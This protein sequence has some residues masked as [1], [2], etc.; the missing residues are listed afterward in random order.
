RL[1]P[2]A[3]QA[4]LRCALSDPLAEAAHDLEQ[5]ACAWL[6]R[7]RS[8]WRAKALAPVREAGLIEAL[9]ALSLAPP[10]IA[11]RVVR[12]LWLAAVRGPSAEVEAPEGQAKT[13]SVA[14]LELRRA[15]R[16]IARCLP[17]ADAHSE[18][19][20]SEELLADL[21]ARFPRV[22]DFRRPGLDR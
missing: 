16:R 6:A 10:L 18:Q 2:G 4:A 5:Q 9:D 19:A 20:R 7:W 14:L 21:V 17:L 12:A 13:A 11:D 8:A 15:W 22:G 1:D 3:F